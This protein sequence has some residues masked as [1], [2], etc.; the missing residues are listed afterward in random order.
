MES[1]DNFLFNKLIFGKYKVVKLISKGSFGNVYLSI[2]IINKKLYA[3][4]AEDRFG[5]KQILEQETFILY[6]LRGRGIPSVITYGRRG[7]YNMLVQT[8]LG[9]SLQDLWEEKNKIFN[10]K[11]IC[12]IAIQ[13]LQRVEYIHSK[14]FLHRDIKPGNFLVGYP[15]DSLIY[16]ID[17]GN[18]RK[19]R[20]SR[21]GKHIQSY[22]INRI[23]GTTLFLS[24][25]VL[26]GNEQSR[27]DDLES[28]GYM[29]I[30][31]YKGELPWSNIKA[32]SID[33]LLE[34]TSE[35]KEKIKIENL[36]KNMPKEMY[37]YMKYVKNLQF[38]ETPNY[39]YLRKLFEDI[40]VKIGQKNDNIFSWAKITKTFNKEMMNISSKFNPQGNLSKQLMKENSIGSK[41]HRQNKLMDF[42]NSKNNRE[43]EN[44]VHK[45]GKNNIN[46][47]NKVISR[48][49]NLDFNK[50][51]INYNNKTNKT[52]KKKFKYSNHMMIK[53][54]KK[55]NDKIKIIKKGFTNTV[56]INKFNNTQILINKPKIEINNIF[57][58][59]INIFNSSNNS[60]SF[61]LTDINYKPQTNFKEGKNNLIKNNYLKFKKDLSYNSCEYKSKQSFILKSKG[62]EDI[63][64]RRI[65]DRANSYEIQENNLDNTL[66]KLKHFDSINFIRNENKNQIFK[67]NKS[68][69]YSFKNIISNENAHDPAKLSKYI[70]TILF[71]NTK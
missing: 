41:I 55:T 19:Y 4:K 24:V 68:H 66:E 45:N 3:I 60:S 58:K 50:Y 17:F 48:N 7:N 33:E 47:N 62:F 2:N 25:N 35:L 57:N 63:N 15:D 14:D 8:L 27:K 12:M 71:N 31:L 38:K 18:S 16:L 32:N 28:L 69:I 1:N 53:Y 52:S 29:Y 13:T 39:K 54:N 59:D 61:L 30:Y 64:Y 34:I 49:I 46:V 6:N 65:K 26:R 42:N 56:N 9:K 44:K 70:L 22:K 11:D 10:L 67:I 40:L 21:T 20:S 36:C 23:F 51:I 5:K 43:K 37:L